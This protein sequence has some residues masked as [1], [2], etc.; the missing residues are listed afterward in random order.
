MLSKRR[1]LF[2]INFYFFGNFTSSKSCVLCNVKRFRSFPLKSLNCTFFLI[3]ISWIP[4][5]SK[6]ERSGRIG[7][8]FPKFSQTIIFF[9]FRNIDI[10]VWSH[11]QVL[12]LTSSYLHVHNIITK[13]LVAYSLKLLANNWCVIWIWGSIFA[14]IFLLWA[15]GLIKFLSLKPKS[16]PIGWT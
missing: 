16:L 10:S 2:F 7:V 1:G 4:M 6:T 9:T 8:I 11:E 5:S 14:C 13:L 15:V 3:F 12:I